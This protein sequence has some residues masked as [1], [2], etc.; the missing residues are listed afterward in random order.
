MWFQLT[1]NTPKMVLVPKR[2]VSG[3]LSVETTK[4]DKRNSC[5]SGIFNR[6]SNRVRKP[7]QRQ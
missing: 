4:T 3:K 1:N 6:A 5:K 2:L 7:I